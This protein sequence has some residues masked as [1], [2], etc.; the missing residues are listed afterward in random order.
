MPKQIGC[1][2]IKFP[3]TRE[4]S[5]PNTH[6]P[7]RSIKGSLEG[8]KTYRKITLQ[9]RRSLLV[10]F[11]IDRPAKHERGILLQFS[12]A[13]QA[14]T[15]R[16]LIPPKSATLSFQNRVRKLGTRPNIKEKLRIKKIL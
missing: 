9:F 4:Q 2:S 8:N 12:L 7:R 6:H 1:L 14:R 16:K 13:A 15:T 11:Q 10:P 3:H 5:A